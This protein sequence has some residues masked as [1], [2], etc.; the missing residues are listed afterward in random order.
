MRV[1]MPSE[2]VRLSDVR[3]EFDSG[4]VQA[5]RGINLSIGAGEFLAIMGPSGCGKSTLLHL[6]GALDRPTSGTV[7]FAGTDLIEIRDLSRFRARTVGFVFQS[8]H[9]LPTLT[10]VENVQMPMFEME[11]PA[12]ERRR[13]AVG[14]LEA[15]GLGHRLGHRPAHLSGGERQRVA[16]ARSL[17]NG[18]QLLLADEPT[19]NLD[20]GSAGEIMTLLE[21]IHRERGMTLVVVTHEPVVA[22]RAGRTVRMFDGRILGGRGAIAGG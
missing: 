3:R 15:V 1:A 2:I 19:G 18:P 14:L 10:A 8:F 9:L 6:L 4:A 21:S 20:S 16:I 12:A 13:R 7:R 22:D 5:L 17:A 11:W